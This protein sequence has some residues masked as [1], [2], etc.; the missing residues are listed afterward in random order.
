M[1]NIQKLRL[2]PSQNMH[3]EIILSK[4]PKRLHRKRLFIIYEFYARKYYAR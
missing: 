3:S 2:N 1:E 4:G